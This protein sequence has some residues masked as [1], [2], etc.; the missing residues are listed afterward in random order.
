MRRF[1]AILITV[2][3]LPISVALGQI[4]PAPRS[5]DTGSDAARVAGPYLNRSFNGRGFNQF[6]NHR[7]D[8]RS[9]HGGRFGRRNGVIFVPSYGYPYIG[10]PLFDGD[11][12]SNQTQF[13]NQPSAPP[14]VVVPQPASPDVTELRREIARL[15]DQ[16]HSTQSQ[17]APPSTEARVPDQPPT[18][19]VFRDQHVE[20]IHNYAIVGEALWAF[21]NGAGTMGRKIPLAQLDLPETAH[22][23][24]EHGIHF[25]TPAASVK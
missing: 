19:L 22:A 3:L 6:G 8:G 20:Q 21:D 14:V 7:F 11:Y 23:N 4:R 5:H 1:A 17:T 10:D 15:S 13:Q 24:A 18:L 9:F 16:L 12:E 2:T 25:S